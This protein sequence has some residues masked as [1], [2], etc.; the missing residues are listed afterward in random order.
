MLKGYKTNQ[1]V[2]ISM[3][4]GSAVLRTDAR[5]SFQQSVGGP[6]VLGIH[7]IRQKPELERPYF[8]HIFSEEDKKN[9]R[10]SGN[11]G[12]VADLNLRGNT[13]EPCLISIDKNT[14]ELVAVRQEHVYIPNEIKGVT[15]TPDEIQKLKNGEQIFVD[16]MKSNQGKEF[17]ANL[18]VQCGKKG[19]RVHIPKGPGIQPTVSRRC[20]AFTD[21]AQGTERRP[22][23][24]CGG[25]EA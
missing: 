20:T 15:L 14:N 12:R 3:N 16:G 8:G 22:Y 23:H 7:G 1:V 6:I 18:A 25:H 9:L 4:F 21:A 11:M 10:E 5:L 24:S 19:Y 2:P 17:N 13:T